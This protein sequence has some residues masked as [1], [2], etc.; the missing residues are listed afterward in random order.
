MKDVAL[1]IP[2]PHQPSVQTTF[3]PHGAEIS[4]DVRFRVSL[5]LK[6]SGESHLPTTASFPL[7]WTIL[8]SER[9]FKLKVL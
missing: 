6:E 4:A 3:D 8:Q 1:A 2:R 5:L 7:E 9:G